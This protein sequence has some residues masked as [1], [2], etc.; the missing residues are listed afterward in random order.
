MRKIKHILFYLDVSL[1]YIKQAFLTVIEY[2]ASIIGWLISNPIQFIVGFATIRFVV[3]QFGHIN[4][5][6]YGQLAVLYGLSVISHGLSMIF[7]VQGWFM[8]FYVIEG[9]FDRF[10]TRPMSVLYQFFFTRVNVFGVTDLL[11]GIIVFAYGL[12]KTHFICNFANILCIIVMLTGATLIRGG[13]LHNLRNK[14]VFHSKLQRF[15]AV[16]A[17]NFRQNDDVPDFDVPGK[18]AIHPDIYNSDRLGELLSGVEHA[19]NRR[20]QRTFWQ[21]CRFNLGGWNFSYDCRGRIFYLRA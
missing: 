17:G 7:F 6:D 1:T 21:N 13:G 4:G 15:W 5:W 12:Y 3:Q 18:S 9:D 16:H 19:W 2:P 14:L 20:N 8:G 10:L 11:P